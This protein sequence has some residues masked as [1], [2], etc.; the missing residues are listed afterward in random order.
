MELIG[1]FNLGFVVVKL[2]P[3]IFIVDQHASDEKYNFEDLSKKTVFQTQ[4]LIRQV[5]Q[6]VDS[7]CSYL[8]EILFSKLLNITCCSG[9]WSCS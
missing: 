8:T 5:S 6:P 9:L 4:R 3:D 1:Q 7:L 2:G